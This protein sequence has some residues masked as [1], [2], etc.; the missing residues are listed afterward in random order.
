[1]KTKNPNPLRTIALQ[2]VAIHLYQRLYHM[3]SDCFRD[4]DFNW[5]G[6]TNLDE[7]TL[8]YVREL[9]SEIL[10]LSCTCH[11]LGGPFDDKTMTAFDR[12]LC[13]ESF[14]KLTQKLDNIQRE[15]RNK[16]IQQ[17]RLNNATTHWDS[18]QTFSAEETET[19]ERYFEYSLPKP[20]FV[21]RPAQPPAKSIC[22]RQRSKRKNV[23]K[24]RP[25]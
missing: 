5:I 6:K 15:R 21:I 24:N 13:A 8:D 16:K 1:M 20:V 12:E 11:R 18:S 4:H 10:H 17:E 25:L 14:E 9:L 2:K 19:I 3:L 22:K 23:R 7:D